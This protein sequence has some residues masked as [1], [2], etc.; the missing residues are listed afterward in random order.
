MSLEGYV[1]PSNSILSVKTLRQQITAAWYQ[2]RGGKK[3]KVNTRLHYFEG[4]FGYEDS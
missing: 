4:L 1:S 2:N 3:E